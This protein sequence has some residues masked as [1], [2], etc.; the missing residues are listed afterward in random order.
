MDGPE[1]VKKKW[2]FPQK[3]TCV[4][5]ALLLAV[6]AGAGGTA[7]YVWRSL[8]PQQFPNWVE[9]PSDGI[10]EILAPMELGLTK[11][12]RFSDGSGYISYYFTNNVGKEYQWFAGAIV[13][14]YYHGEF[15]AVCPAE[16]TFDRRYKLGPGERPE[17]VF[18]CPEGTLV[19]PGRYRLVANDVG[20][21][22]FV[23]LPDGSITLG[24]DF[25]C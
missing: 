17:R 1:N 5:L 8:P 14:Y 19:M 23:I 22:E 4:L 24:K 10:E 18:D 11:V 20:Q 9:A 7:V 6:M 25:P 21:V 13:E 2:H 16:I 3:V 15:H 12:Q